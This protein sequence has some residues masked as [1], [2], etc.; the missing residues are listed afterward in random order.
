MSRQN[1]SHNG[2]KSAILRRREQNSAFQIGRLQRVLKN[3]YVNLKKYKINSY[4]KTLKNKIMLVDPLILKL[5]KN[6][7]SIIKLKKYYQLF[8]ISFRAI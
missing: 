3:N 7:L 8:K 5:K 2:R 4:H 1:H 6:I